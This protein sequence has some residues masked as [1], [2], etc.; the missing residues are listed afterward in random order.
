M[1]KNR[2]KTTQRRTD[3]LAPIVNE[4]AK[5]RIERGIDQVELANQLGVTDYL[6]AK[7]EC[8]IR[9]PSTFNLY[10]WADVLDAKFLICANDNIH[11]A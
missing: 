5:I 10:C 7:W 2:C 6:V 3:F 8:G 4:L 9:T 11:S 1:K